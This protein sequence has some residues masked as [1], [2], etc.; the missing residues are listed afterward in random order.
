MRTMSLFESGDSSGLVS[1]A[2]LFEEERV[3]P[4]ISRLS[5]DKLISIA[6][7]GGWPE[8]IAT[9]TD[10]TGILPEQYIAA[11]AE[12]TSQA[13]TIQGAIPISY[14]ICLPQLRG[15]M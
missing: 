15:Q 12:M 3:N 13:L 11:L 8:N 10:D 4:D 9:P 5:L 6:T 14:C 1:L 2:G 7:R